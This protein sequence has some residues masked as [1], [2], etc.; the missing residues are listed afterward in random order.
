MP[1]RSWVREYFEIVS[2]LECF[3]SKEVDFVKVLLLNESKAVGLV[4]ALREYVKADLSSNGE[5]QVQVFEFF[6]H[7]LN[8]VF[9]DLVFQIEF[10]V[11]VAFIPA[12]I[13]SDG[14][15][16]EHSGSE[17]DECASLDGD[18]DIGEVFHDPVHNALN[19]VFAE[20]FG[21]SLY[22]E[23]VSVFVGDESVLREVPGKDLSNSY[24]E[25]LFLLGQIAACRATGESWA[26]VLQQS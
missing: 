24:S 15:Y 16:I 19:V 18:V 21:D 13:S 17:F 4:P 8:H 1:N 10:F 6:L 20:M 2:S 14:R 22:F 9:P 11:F 5:G 12:A 25:L 3:V 7:G 26:S 23:Q